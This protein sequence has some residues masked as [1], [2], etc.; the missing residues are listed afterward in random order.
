MG[1]YLGNSNMLADFNLAVLL[2]WLIA[3]LVPL[4]A[5]GLATSERRS[6]ASEDDD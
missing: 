2:V 3:E 1:P 4:A 6:S 5:N